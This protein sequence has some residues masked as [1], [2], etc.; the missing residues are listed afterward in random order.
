MRAVSI[1]FRR[2][3]AAYFM[4][5]MGFVCMTILLV[6]TG[7][8]FS[9][10]LIGTSRASYDYILG[11]L[12]FVNLGA[13]D[14]AG[15]LSVPITLPTI[16]PGVLPLTLYQQGVFLSLAKGTAVSGGRAVLLLE[17]STP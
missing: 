1:Q 17:G 4:T 8:I 6:F 11:P 5:P 10:V 12:T 15:K 13:V 14:A 3:L 7:I 9:L 2:E 16:G